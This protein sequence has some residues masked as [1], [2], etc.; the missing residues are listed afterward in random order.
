MPIVPIPGDC[1]ADCGEVFIEAGDG[2]E[3]TGTGTEEDPFVV[4]ATGGGGGVEFA[5]SDAYTFARQN[6]PAPM[7]AVSLPFDFFDDGP[8]PIGSWA[9]DANGSVF[10]VTNGGIYQFYI[11]VDYPLGLVGGDVIGVELSVTGGGIPS[12][13]IQQSYLLSRFVLQGPTMIYLLAG[14][15][16][17][18]KLVGHT[19]ATPSYA[20]IQA[21]RVL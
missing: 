14:A 2:V 1:D 4:S 6:T 13:Y 12:L 18:V 9:T 15:Q 10:T 19:G 8:E 16:L 5:S 21:K 7:G 11:N 3:V 20:E 17:S